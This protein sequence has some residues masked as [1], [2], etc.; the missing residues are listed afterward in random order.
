MRGPLKASLQGLF[1]GFGALEGFGGLRIKGLRKSNVYV[2]IY[3]QKITHCRPHFSVCRT[4]MSFVP[5]SI[6]SFICL[7]RRHDL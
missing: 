2:Y 3:I 1:K 5:L 4:Y 6:S 7:V